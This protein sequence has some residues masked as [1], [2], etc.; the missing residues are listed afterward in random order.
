ME[1]ISVLTLHTTPVSICLYLQY[2][3]V[4][5]TWK[6]VL[7]GATNHKIFGLLI[8]PWC[9]WIWGDVE[10]A[11]EIDGMQVQIHRRDAAS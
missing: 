3:I 9:N 6:Y 7:F 4:L 5:N 8:S 10:A 2:N 11:Y 1:N